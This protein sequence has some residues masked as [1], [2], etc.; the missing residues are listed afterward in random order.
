MQEKKYN[1]QIQVLENRVK[2]LESKNALY[3]KILNNLPVGI[4]VFDRYGVSH[5]INQKQSELLGLPDLLVGIGKFNVLT[6]PY[7]VKTGA[8]QIYKEVYKGKKYEHTY[9]YNLGIEENKWDT[10][11]DTRIFDEKIIPLQNNQQD[12]EYVLAVLDDVTDKKKHEVDLKESEERFRSIFK[13]DKSVKLIIDPKTGQ[14]E[15]C[16]TAALEFYG[17][18]EDE[19]LNKNISEINTL[20]REDIDKEMAEAVRMNKN[21]FYFKHRLANGDIKDVAVYS[22]PIKLKTKDK[23]F[24]IIHDITTQKKLE[25]EL[26]ATKQR[27]DMAMEATKDGLWDWNLLTNEIYFS[28]NWKIMLGYENNELPNDFAVWE[29]LTHPEDVKKSWD[30]LNEHINGKN[31]RFEIEFRMKHKNGNWIDILSRANAY[32]D[33]NGT[34]YRV[35]GTHVDIRKQKQLEKQLIAE[36]VKVNN[37]ADEIAAINEELNQTNQEYLTLNKELKQTNETL[38]ETINKLEESEIKFKTVFDILDVG[39]SITDEHG[40]IIDCN[41]ASEKILGI[42]K[43]EHLAR[44][45]AGKEWDIVRPDMSPMPPNEFASVRALTENRAILNIEMGI[46]KPKGIAWISVNATP[47]KLK[48]YGVV[49]AYIDNTARKKAEQER[50]VFNR[51]FEAFLDQTS[52]F[53]YF[54]D[55]NSRF[56]FCSQTLA[57]ITGHKHW[58]EMIGKHDL[59]VFPP[60]TAKIYYEEELP[61]FK[62]GKPLLEKIDPYYDK[63]GNK[64][65]VYTNKWPLFDDNKKVVGIFGISRDITDRLETE[66]KIKDSEKQLKE[67]NATKDKFFSIIAHDLLSP[68]NAIL[69]FSKLAIKKI[70]NQE[71]DKLGQFCDMIHK[72]AQQSFNLLNNLLEWSRIQT[73]KI[74][75]KPQHLN[76][77]SV[78]DETLSLLYANISEKEINV[79]T[80]NVEDLEIFADKFML[81]TI[82]RNL[83]SNSIKFT[84]NEGRITINS[85]KQD[86]SFV[87][88]IEDT[89]I[90]ISELDI[91]KLFKIENNFSK[92]GTNNEKGTGLGLILCKEFVE[93]HGGKIW[94][95]SELEKWTKFSFTIRNEIK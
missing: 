21:Y 53:V 86:D 90:G 39:L 62:E 82:L 59:E 72:S 89:G 47:L 12:T 92:E 81:E 40:N 37:Y 46:V 65:Y 70:D 28:P 41:K 63:N 93:K 83:I 17:F 66:Q 42:T 60:D 15:D 31:E 27:F 69:G 52:D 8:S 87:I 88:S 64:G 79:N 75:F 11:K 91:E 2:E 77:K 14:I 16:N 1:K 67:L 54:K 18:S 9:E 13:Q 55:I 74:K 51:N 36:K 33:N 43:E 19:L 5:L 76:L 58:K 48:G 68:Y 34:A 29:Q 84:P 4:Q 78:V 24:S 35:V 32:F 10:R 38:H 85:S 26:A 49:I 25:T 6:D 80:L 22:S 45:Y 30:L 57:E 44:N 56:I 50:L 7:A 95:E 23:L 3:E 94:V 20:T 71:F 73:G 61:V